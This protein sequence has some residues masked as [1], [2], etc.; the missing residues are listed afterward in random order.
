MYNFKNINQN[1]EGIDK[2]L[3]KSHIEFEAQVEKYLKLY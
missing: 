1:I 3:S 2:D